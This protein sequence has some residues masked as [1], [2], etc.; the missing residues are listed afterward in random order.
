[1]GWLSCTAYCRQ[2][3]RKHGPPAPPP[4][5]LHADALLAVHALAG[6]HVAGDQGILL[7]TGNEYAGVAM[8][9]HHHLGAALHATAAAATATAAATP[10][11]APAAAKAPAPASTATLVHATTA[12]EAATATA[13]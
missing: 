5:L 9:L 2:T 12:T 3:E 8:L 6:H 13:A 10:A 11:A 1:M 7:A 4:H